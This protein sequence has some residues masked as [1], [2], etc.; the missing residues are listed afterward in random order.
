MLPFY[1]SI[2]AVS[3]VNT[4]D[5]L[6]CTDHYCQ[7][8]QAVNLTRVSKY[9]S[10]LVQFM[11]AFGAPLTAFVLPSLTFNW[12]FRSK[13]KRATAVFPPSR[14]AKSLSSAQ[15]VFKDEKCRI[16]PSYCNASSHN[17]VSHC[18]PFS[19]FN[20]NVA[21]FINCIIF[22]A[23]LGFW[24]GAVSPCNCLTLSSHWLC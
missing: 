23:Y 5:L 18:R 6:S 22:V 12:V 16:S 13:A 3:A 14:S 9:A 10:A 20:W 11:G 4:Q 19:Y 2:N 24:G 15:P 7:H 1:S 21:I 17:L 8:V